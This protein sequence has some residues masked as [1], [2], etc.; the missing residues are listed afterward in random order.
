MLFV[1][2]WAQFARRC[3]CKKAQNLVSLLQLTSCF[4]F[5]VYSFSG[6]FWEILD[7]LLMFMG[8]PRLPGVWE[9]R[10]SVQNLCSLSGQHFE[11][12]KAS[13]LGKLQR[14]F[15]SPVYPTPCL[16]QEAFCTLALSLLT[17]S[18][19]LAS[20][21]H[22]LQ[23]SLPAW[24]LPSATPMAAP[25]FHCCGLHGARLVA[26]LLKVRILCYSLPLHKLSGTF[27]LLW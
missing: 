18:A 8:M 7:I 23:A 25:R 3:E 6:A 17:V 16:N 10:A 20:F 19:E 27:S 9:Y 4:V 15:L 26:A 5:C 2:C 11:K 12:E 13:M 21:K 24:V 22:Y 1:I 14:Y